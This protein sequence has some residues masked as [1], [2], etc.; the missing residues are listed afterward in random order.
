MSFVTTNTTA[1]T[2]PCYH[3]S[4]PLIT[5]NGNISTKWT[6]MWILNVSYIPGQSGKYTTII[7]GWWIIYSSK[8]P[9]NHQLYRRGYSSL[10]IKHA[11]PHV[12]QAYCSRV[13]KIKNPKCHHRGC[14][15]HSS[16]CHIRY[17]VISLLFLIIVLLR[18]A[19]TWRCSR[20][21]HVFL[22]FRY[23]PGTTA[24]SDS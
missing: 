19:G 23:T 8:I 22:C 3:R 12:I 14:V 20:Q 2:S 17:Q 9:N 6:L 24:V 4:T 1:I 13:I 7:R 10:Y 15:T 11:T 16:Q 21:S 5:L 18:V